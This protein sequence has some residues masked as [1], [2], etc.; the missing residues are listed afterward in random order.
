M[1]ERWYGWL[2]E[3]ERDR[4]LGEGGRDESW[5]GDSDGDGGAGAVSAPMG[6]GEWVGECV[7]G[8]P[9]VEQG[10]VTGGSGVSTQLSV[11]PTTS[12]VLCAWLR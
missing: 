10:E 2:A 7:R 6:P 9:S 8:V 12:I 5:R 4:E 11:W 3:N 1:G